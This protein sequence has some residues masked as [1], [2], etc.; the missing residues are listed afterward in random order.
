MFSAI[1][2]LTYLCTQHQFTVEV[3]TK[4]V[5]SIGVH[6]TSLQYRC[7]Q[8]RFTVQVYKKPDKSTLFKFFVKGLSQ[9][10]KLATQKY[11]IF[12]NI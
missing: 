11:N 9:V 1:L 7:T 3:Y 6:K 12:T 5:C 10:E 8:N 4:P 2:V